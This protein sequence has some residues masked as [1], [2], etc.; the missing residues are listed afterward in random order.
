M[1]APVVIVEPVRRMLDADTAL[2][3]LGITVTGASA[4][5]ASAR[6]TVVPDMA[7][8]HGIAH[9]GIVFALAD[10]AFAA[11]ANSLSEGIATAEAQISYL[12][13]ARIGEELTAEAIVAFHEGRRV[14]VDVT[15]LAG[16]LSVALYRGQGRLLRTP[17]ATD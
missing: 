2:S 17:S 15:V 14:V 10:T 16:Q 8:G 5:R 12:S 6:L 11:A 13:P 1:S 4:G 7:N 3:R 9:G